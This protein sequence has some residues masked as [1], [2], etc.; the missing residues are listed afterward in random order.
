[1]KEEGCVFCPSSGRSLCDK[2]AGTFKFRKGKIRCPCKTIENVKNID[3]KPSKIGIK[4]FKIEGKKAKKKK[5]IVIDK[6]KTLNEL[7]DDL[8]E[9]EQEDLETN[10]IEISDIE[11][12]AFYLKLE[13][14]L[15]K[16]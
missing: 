3:T 4:T 16:I 14:D 10:E 1:M 9:Y 8:E 13:E 6:L 2:K 5:W 12:E 7:N 15:G 11:E